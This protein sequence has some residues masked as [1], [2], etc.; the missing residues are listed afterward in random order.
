MGAA[1]AAVLAELV[2]TL[3]LK[4]KQRTAMQAVLGGRFSVHLW[5]TLASGK[6]WGSGGGMTHQLGSPRTNRKPRDV[7]KWQ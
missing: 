7:T 4:D 1:V 3:T 5:L 6:H 2:D